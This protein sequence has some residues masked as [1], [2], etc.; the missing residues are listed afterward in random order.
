MDELIKNA[1]QAGHLALTEPEAKKLCYQYL[2]PVPDFSITRSPQDALEAS[3]KLGFPLVAKI[4]SREIIH[5]SDAG[6]VML[7]LNS[8][9]DVE[10]AFTT[11]L[12]RAM[13]TVSESKIE[14]VLLERMQS[15]GAELVIGA[16]R[17]PQFG[18]VLMF[19][20]GGI[21][22]EALRD[23]TF[24]LVPVTRQ[25]A[26][27]MLNGIRTQRL[28]SGFRGVPAANR[29][30]LIQILQAASRMVVENPEIAELDL[31]PVIANEKGAIAVDARVILSETPASTPPT[32][33]RPDLLS[34]FFK[35][36]SVAVIGASAVEGK[37]GH[38]VL[39]SLSKYEY[40]GK[41]TPINPTSDSILGLKC[42]PSIAKT[43]E[44]VELAVLTVPSKLAPS[45]A[46]EC[47]T[48]GVKAII[49]VSGGFKEAGMQDVEKRT[50]EI[51][52]KYG[53]RII[54][55]NCI[56]V[57]DG[58]SRLDTFF[59]SH[60][61]MI[62]PQSGNVAFITQSGTFGATM[63]EWAAEAGIGISK[64]V[65]YGNRCDV[66]EGDLVEFFGKDPETA[67]VGIYVEGLDNGRKLYEVARTVTRT[68]P[69][70]VLKSGKTAL[71]SKAAKSHTGWLAGSYDVAEA[72]FRQAGMI[73]SRNVEDLFDKVKALSMQPLPKG[74]DV[75]MVTNGAGPCVMAADRM[76][77]IGIPVA[78]LSQSTKTE[79]AQKLPSYCLI[80]DT[81]IDLTGSA[82]S[83]DYHIA[84]RTLASD[85]EVQVL[86]PFFVFQD[87]PLDEGIVQVL[88]EIRKL[89]KAIVGCAA[90][91]PY[92]RMMSKKIE[93]LGIPIYETGE[94]AVHAV[95]ALIQQA[96]VSGQL[97]QS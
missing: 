29:E 66:D 54:G 96:R 7:G 33:P 39:K 86:M 38:E 57:L 92:T 18:M 94:R 45:V 46:E 12:N 58:H 24:K 69:I 32:R 43:P 77:Q 1:L 95:D 79:L 84:L 26:S 49:I 14:G 2:I 85:P 78:H 44:N 62:R 48:K 41:V 82:T 17:D 93:A 75:I 53:M 8:P 42:Y 50:V 28:L 13:T 3:K 80:S 35:P 60:E 5:K 25:D 34:Y 6:G 4:I 72:A 37:I 88:A 47:G 51:A 16:T 11:L 74:K 90:G 59:Q 63:I 23:V 15:K 27:E 91:G 22:V 70:V 21:F 56:G 31:N 83:N 10:A 65:S 76:E 67:L 19:G 55:P 40:K 71:G 64:F 61:K 81:T 52:R 20:I 73:V 30:T 68:K 87:T 97:T 89:G 9:Q 36:E